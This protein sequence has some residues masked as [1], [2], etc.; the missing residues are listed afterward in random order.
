MT[1]WICA[2]AI[3][4]LA[5]RL[6]WP[7][8]R[9]GSLRATA[10]AVAGAHLADRYRQS[11]LIALG[12]WVVALGYTRGLYG[13]ESTAAFVIGFATTVLLWRIYFYWAGQILG[14]AIAASKNPEHLGR[15]AAFAHWITILGIIIITAV[16]DEL[17]IP[18][19]LGDTMP[20][21]AAVILGG[22]ALYVSSP[23]R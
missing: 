8:P 21:W 11:L 1:L 15:V 7:V 10:W 23:P 19:P 6:G 2:A 22:P 14:D 16:G 4:Y 9:L 20:A 12:E 5:A 3:D 13:V 18:H 17:V